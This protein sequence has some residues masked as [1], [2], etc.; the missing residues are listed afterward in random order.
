MQHFGKNGFLF[1]LCGFALLSAGDTVIKS[2]AGE[3]PGT[4][5]AALRFCFGAVG[6]GVILWMKEG[7]AGFKIPL[8]KFQ[9]LRGLG[10]AASS[11]CFFSAIYLM[12]L[13]E[14]VAIQFTGPMMTALI[15]AVFL[16][17]RTTKAT[18]IAS[19]VAFGG[20][21]LILRPNLE[22]LGWAAF[23]PLAAAFTMALVMIGNRA[24]A[25]SGSALQM[26]FLIAAISAPLLL[27]AATIGH[28]SGI[29][30]FQVN[31][32][33]W[34]ILARCALVAVTA[35]ISH[36]LVYLGTTR[37]SAAQIAPA[38]FV[39]ILIAIALGFIYFGDVPDM[40]SVIGST[41][42]IVAGIFLW[43][44]NAETVADSISETR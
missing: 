39:Q 8:P 5:V 15:S 23:L 28:F 42:I 16:G 3:W 33:D 11:L 12:P 4:A 31:M 22:L 25:G 24:V 38:V 21:V 20:V 17:E 26:Q 27:L 9:L 2:M 1:A 7:K 10:L 30:T 40:L 14:A 44:S 6:L 19:L 34:S 18:W 41:I 32:P 35:S 36:S 37:A 13:A 29:A 43:R